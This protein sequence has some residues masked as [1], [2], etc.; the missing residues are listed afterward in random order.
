MKQKNSFVL[1][2]RD[3]KGWTIYI[4]CPIKELKARKK[5]P[6]EM[7]KMLVDDLFEEKAYC[8]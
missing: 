5:V 3:A 2:N 4:G 6:L 8:S 7:E 1:I